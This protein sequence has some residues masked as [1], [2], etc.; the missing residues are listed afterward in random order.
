MQIEFFCDMYISEDLK[1]KEDELKKKL[2]RNKLR[3]GTYVIALAQGEQNNLDFFSAILFRQ[4]LFEETPFLVV[5]LADG[6]DDALYL[7][8]EITKKVCKET[9]NADIRNYILN[10]QK[11]FKEGRV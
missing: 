11:E 3:A 8:E 1:S 5:G 6:Y 7:V 10:R 4:H 9:G 2:L